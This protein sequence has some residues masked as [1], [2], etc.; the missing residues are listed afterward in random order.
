MDFKKSGLVQD[1]FVVKI[2][3]RVGFIC[4]SF[5]K[6]EHYEYSEGHQSDYSLFSPT[7]FKIVSGSVVFRRRQIHTK[8]L[9]W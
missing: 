4:Q 2:F 1:T 5:S 7:K 9:H 6:E 8:R 3:G